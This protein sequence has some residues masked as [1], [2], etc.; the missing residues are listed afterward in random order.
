[1]TDI[2]M[3]VNTYNK[4]IIKTFYFFQQYGCC[5]C[6]DSDFS[7][8]EKLHEIYDRIWE[9]KLGKVNKNTGIT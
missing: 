4:I 1:M 2:N 5:S 3:D 9:I 8:V 6:G 7:S